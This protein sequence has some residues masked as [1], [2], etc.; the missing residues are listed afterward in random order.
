MRVRRQRTPDA[1]PVRSG[2]LLPDAPRPRRPLL[3]LEQPAHQLGPLD[4]CLD[5]D[6][7]AVA[8]EPQ[9]AIQRPHVEEDRL[10]AE[11]LSPHR[12]PA[13]RDAQRMTLALRGLE[14]LRQRVAGVG[15]HDAQHP[16]GIQ[17]GVDVVDDDLG[18]GP[19][20][21]AAPGREGDRRTGSSAD[22]EELTPRQHGASASQERGAT[23]PPPGGD[24]T[25][26][27]G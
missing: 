7:A 11:L 9:D 27:C 14:Q 2:L 23:G 24:G 12:V 10:A 5:V 15:L 21:A 26:H 8:V 19:W 16:G 18:P 1:Q 17:L 4:S 25:A 20:P 3:R 13:A 6:Q 22:L